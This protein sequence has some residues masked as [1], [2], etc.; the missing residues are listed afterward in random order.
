MKLMR[1]PEFWN[2]L[3]PCCE[4]KIGARD[5]FIPL[6]HLEKHSA[7]FM[8][9]ILQKNST[10]RGWQMPHVMLV[11]DSRV[12]IAYLFPGRRLF[13]LSWCLKNTSATEAEGA[14]L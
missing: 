10:D 13:A 1:S 11:T 12:P 14:F 9:Y 8:G 6:L 5:F 4:C 7:V 3:F 2:I